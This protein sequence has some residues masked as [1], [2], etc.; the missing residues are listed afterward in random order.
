[1]PTVMVVDDSSVARKNLINMLTKAGYDVILEV[2]NGIKAIDYYKKSYPDI[3]AMDV[4][5]PD[6]DGIEATKQILKINP[7]AKIIMISMHNEK[8]LVFE[9]LKIGAKHYIVKPFSYEKIIDIFDKV[10]RL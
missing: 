6:I 4:E 3:V 8:N 7:K 10:S 1:M 5:L 9:A 2:D